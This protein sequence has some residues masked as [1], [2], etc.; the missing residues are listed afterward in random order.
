MGAGGRKTGDPGDLLPPRDGGSLCRG[1][2]GVGSPP[3]GSIAGKELLPKH[4]EEPGRAATGLWKR[5]YGSCVIEVK[6]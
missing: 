2:C 3:T 4:K 1:T 5:H 6:Q